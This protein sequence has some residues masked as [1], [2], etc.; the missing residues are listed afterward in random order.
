MKKQLLALFS[1]ITLTFTAIAGNIQN[2]RNCGTM[3]NLDR[4][5][6][7]DP[8]LADRMQQIERQ[9]ASYVAAQSSKGQN[10]ADMVI[11]IPV[12]F[13]VI[14]NTA[15]QNISDAQCIAQLNQLN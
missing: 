7:E 9:T 4:L 15:A 3:E 2:H 13:H 8:A 11:T 5:K 6:R 14:Y 1:V 12:V 10:S